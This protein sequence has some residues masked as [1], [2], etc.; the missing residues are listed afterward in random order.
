M[1]AV[2]REILRTCPPAPNTIRKCA[3][4]VVVP[5]GNPVTGRDGQTIDSILIPKGT[6]LFIRMPSSD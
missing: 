2:V 4:D 1:E 3:Q 5:L 6:I